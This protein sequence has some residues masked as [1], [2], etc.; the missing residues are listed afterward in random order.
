MSESVV[1]AIDSLGPYDTLVID[2]LTFDRP[3]WSHFCVEEALQF[4]ERWR[5]RQTYIV[6]F[7]CGMSVAEANLLLEARA[8]ALRQEDIFFGS[9]AP[10]RWQAEITERPIHQ[11]RSLETIDMPVWRPPG[12]NIERIELAVDG[13][14]ISFLTKPLINDD[15]DDA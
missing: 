6:G 12:E 11:N 3:N 4:V 10:N 5:P 2:S 9:L 1:S 14:V 8:A 7:T 13:T 15:D